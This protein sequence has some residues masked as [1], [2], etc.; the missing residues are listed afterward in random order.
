MYRLE[1]TGS[2]LASGYQLYRQSRQEARSLQGCRQV[3]WSAQRCEWT[4]SLFAATQRADH[5]QTDGPWLGI[6]TD[7]LDRFGV[8]T[9][10]TGA[11]DGIHYFHLT[12]PTPTP[13]TNKAAR[14]RKLDLIRQSLG[15]RASVFITNSGPPSIGLG[16]PGP[17]S[18][19]NGG[20]K[21]S[22]SPFTGEHGSGI[23][24]EHPRALFVRPH[25][26][27]FVLGAE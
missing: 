6:E 13:E 23:L 21:R 19:M 9:M 22:L 4:T 16:I 11:L 14:Q 17:Q 2:G 8:P 27:V 20:S 15:K 10:P 1:R 18:G 25:E 7:D 3:H 24:F 12:R 5:D 26:V